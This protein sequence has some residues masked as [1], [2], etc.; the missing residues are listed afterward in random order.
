[1]IPDYNLEFAHIYADEQFGPEQAKGLARANEIIAKLSAE[2]KTFVTSVLIDEFNPV[3]NTLDENEFIVQLRV[4]NTPVDFIGY[5]SYF[6]SIAD[7]II[8]ELPTSMLTL[9]HFHNP[10]KSVLM[11][12]DGPIKIGLEQTK[13]KLKH[14]CAILSAAWT[15]CRLGVH[16]LP[17]GA[18]KQLTR[19]QKFVAKKTITILPE[20]YRAGEER[21][22]EIIKNL[23]YA[24]R[25]PDIQYEF[26]S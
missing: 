13:P 12:Q 22:L 9:K 7:L 1:M 25:L 17:D 18:L 16:P 15:L 21:V 8:R 20:K 11:L 19:G 14:T 5:E 2:G 3:V 24:N 26:F 23:P 4:N 10:D 6:T